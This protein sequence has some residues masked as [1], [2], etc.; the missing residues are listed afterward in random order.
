MNDS[1]GDR[2]KSAYEDR[3]RTFLPRR[4]NVIIRVDGR[5]FSTYTQSCVK[6]FDGDLICDMNAVA[7]ALASGIQ[8]AKMVYTQSDEISIWVTDYDTIETDAW[9][10][11]NIQKMVSISASIATASFAKARM[12]RALKDNL[13]QWKY[14]DIIFPNFDARCFIIPDLYEVANYFLWRS[15]DA[16]RNSVSMI[17]HYRLGHKECQNKSTDELKALCPEWETCSDDKKYG[18]VFCKV[19][20]TWGII[21]LQVIPTFQWWKVMVDMNMPKIDLSVAS[22]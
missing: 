13:E 2:M 4:T 1:L 14:K 5:S 11:N 19:G 15:K 17:A 9:F 12:L 20:Q 16:A 18:R 10:D 8:G 22:V 7:L 3:A 21:Q 6:P